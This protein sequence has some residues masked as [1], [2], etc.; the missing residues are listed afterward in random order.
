MLRPAS[1]AMQQFSWNS[2]GFGAYNI[3]S[4]NNL[5]PMSYEDATVKVI[6]WGDQQWAAYDDADTFM[7]KANFA[8][9]E[10]LGGVFVWAISHDSNDT[11]SSEGL[12]LAT[13]RNF[14]PAE[15]VTLANNSPTITQSYAVEQC[16]WTK[17]DQG[18]PADY[19]TVL[20]QD[21]S[22]SYKGDIMQYANYCDGAGTHT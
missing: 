22:I 9:S 4:D 14:I 16:M 21:A 18:C 12:A 5:T 15:E 6:T 19:S 3:I 11:A 13:G 10:Y 1:R 7:L 8:R 2:N 20:R 17:C